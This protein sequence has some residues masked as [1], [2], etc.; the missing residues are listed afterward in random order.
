M[1]SYASTR[2]RP[3]IHRVESEY[4]RFDCI[5]DMHKFGVKVQQF[6]W[7][8]T[9]AE[10]TAW[11]SYSRCGPWVAFF[12]SQSVHVFQTSPNAR[13]SFP[14]Q[15]SASAM[16]LTSRPRVEVW[17]CSNANHADT[18]VL[19]NANEAH[20]Q[21]FADFFAVGLL[22][23]WHDLWSWFTHVFQQ[24]P[25]PVYRKIWLSHRHFLPHARSRFELH[26]VWG[27][28]YLVTPKLVLTH[29]NYGK[30]GFTQ[31]EFEPSHALSEVPGTPKMVFSHIKY[32]KASCDREITSRLG[33]IDRDITTLSAHALIGHCLGNSHV[34][35]QKSGSQYSQTCELRPPK[36]LEKNGLDSQMVSLARFGSM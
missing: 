10:I 24:I 25:D 35:C 33:R 21:S 17:R 20:G 14:K 13:A 6:M 3:V 36:G 11:Y 29:T 9:S 16:M 23:G 15:N 22:S 27:R 26:E 28:F 2:M 4:E 34:T 31:S 18:L 1:E 5:S 12:L 32:G 30:A 19:H 7:T 8:E